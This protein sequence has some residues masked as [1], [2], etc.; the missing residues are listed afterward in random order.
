MRWDNLFDDLEGQLEQELSAEELDLRVEEE[1]T[2]LSRLTIR[3]R[4]LALNAATD[5]VRVTVGGSLTISV[6][7]V[8]VGRDW[9]S[10]EL[11]DESERARSCIIPVPAISTMTFTREQAERSIGAVSE[12]A[13]HASLPGRLGFAFVL[14]DLCRRRVAVDLRTR[15]QDF[16]GTI[17]RVGR[18]HLDLAIHDRDAFRRQSAVSQ[19][20]IIPF[21]SVLMILVG[22]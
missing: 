7:P 18:D 10:A 17:D 21:D 11:V 2:R 16:H 22:R 19:I 14:R 13:S 1:R 6:R 20:R 3:D 9:M 4:L 12:E 15:E 8:T 5:V